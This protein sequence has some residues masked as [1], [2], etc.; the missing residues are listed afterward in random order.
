MEKIELYDELEDC[1][2]S[3]GKLFCSYPTNNL[4]GK[5]IQQQLGKPPEMVMFI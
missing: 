5:G 4:I 1:P 3:W 2:T